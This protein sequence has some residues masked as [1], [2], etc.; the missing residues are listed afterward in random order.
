[1][2]D[3]CEHGWPKPGGCK[4]CMIKEEVSAVALSEGLWADMD[5]TARAIYDKGFNR[6]KA[7]IRETFEMALEVKPEISAKELFELMKKQDLV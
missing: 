6:M 4:L 1:M 7:G 5:E 3:I 2:N